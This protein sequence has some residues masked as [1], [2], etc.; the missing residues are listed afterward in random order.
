MLA[1]EMRKEMGANFYDELV[2]KIFK[3]VDGK[4]AAGIR[5]F[6]EFFKLEQDELY[7]RRVE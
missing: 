3:N 2:N 5:L 4:L 1:R 6:P 7:V